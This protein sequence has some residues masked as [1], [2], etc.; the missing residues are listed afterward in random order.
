MGGGDTEQDK[1]AV[2]QTNDPLIRVVRNA[3]DHGIKN[4]SCRKGRGKTR[5]CPNE[6]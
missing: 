6:V 5:A 1:S 4:C 3:T 2:E